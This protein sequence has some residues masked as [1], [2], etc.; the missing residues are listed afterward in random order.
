MTG[1][2]SSTSTGSTHGSARTATSSSMIRTAH[3][4]GI[5][6]IADLVPNHT[7]DHHP[8]FQSAREGRD[9]PYHD[10]YVWADEKPEEKPGDVV[11]PDQEELQLGLRREGQTLV[12]APLLLAPARSQRLQPGCSRRD[13]PDRRLLARAGNQRLPASTRFR[14]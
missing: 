11:F 2:T 8:W 13:R 1:T 4:R 7:S 5:R 12:P 9:S 14:S 6:V 10:F 3:D